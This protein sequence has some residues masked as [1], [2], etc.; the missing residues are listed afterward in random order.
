[1][2]EAGLT[3]GG[4][5]RHFDSRDE[6]IL[7]SLTLALQDIEAWEKTVATAPCQAFRSYISEAHRDNTVEGCPIAGLVTDV[8]RAPEAV[9]D[10]YTERVMRVIDTLVKAFPD[11]D[12][13]TRRSEATFIFTSC[14]GA[15]CLSRAV[16]DPKLSKQIIEDAL[17]QI[18]LYYSNRRTSK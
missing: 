4:F 17:S 3:V 14:I 2:K 12:S 6:L 16:S 7:E 1:M 9:R 11:G 18:L 13:G 8:S 5:Y 15:I 10:L